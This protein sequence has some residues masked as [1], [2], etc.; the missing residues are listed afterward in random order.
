[1]CEYYVSRSRLYQR[2]AGGIRSSVLRYSVGD[3]FSSTTFK[4]CFKFGGNKHNF[5]CLW[6]CYTADKITRT[7][8]LTPDCHPVAVRSRKYS[9]EDRVFVNEEVRRL[10][11][12][13]IIEPS[14]SPWRAQVVVVK[15]ENHKQRMAMDYSQTINRFTLL[16]AF[17]LPHVNY[18]VNQIAQFR[19]FSTVDLK[20]AMIWSTTKYLCEKRINLTLHLRQVRDYTNLPACH[21]VSL[22]ALHVFS[23]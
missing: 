10:L 5:D 9:Q 17:P 20:S 8:N 2:S 22:M 19:V 18:L 21:L 13:G 7:V 14:Q 11:K 16:D 4:R 1:M 15:G 6:V 3:L 23:E 12:D